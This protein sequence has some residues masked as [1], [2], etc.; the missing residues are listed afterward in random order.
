MKKILILASFL[1]G[2]SCHAQVTR[3]AIYASANC[4][5]IKDIET[6]EVTLPIPAPASS[7]YS[8]YVIAGGIRQSFTPKVGLE[9]GSRFDYPLTSR[10]FLTSGLAVSYLR[11]QRT[12]EVTRLSSEIQVQVNA[13][14]PTTV[15]LPFG[16]IY[17][18]SSMRDADGNIMRSPAALPKRSE[19]TLAHASKT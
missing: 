1:I 5:I 15:G 11:F 16:Q 8:S 14:P 6:E 13:V 10:L 3:F 19:N 7:G 9:I 4:A 2:I 18:W 12:I 17:G